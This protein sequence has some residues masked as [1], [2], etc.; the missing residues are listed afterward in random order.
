MNNLLIYIL[1]ILLLIILLKKKDILVEKFEYHLTNEE[2]IKHRLTFKNMPI[3]TVY[4]DSNTQ[5]IELD[6][7]HKFMNNIQVK[8]ENNILNIKNHKNS[9]YY[10]DAFTYKKN[11]KNNK[12]LTICSIP[13]QLLLI[14]NKRMRL[15]SDNTISIGYLNEID[16]DLV[17]II[18]KSQINYTNLNN[19]RFIKVTKDDLIN[20][21]FREKTLDIFVY[22]NTL[23]NEIFNNI[24]KEDFNLVEYDYKVSELEI[25][26]EDEKIIGGNSEYSLDENTLKFYLPF[27]KKEIQTFSKNNNSKDINENNNI[28]YNTLLI[29]TLLFSF[30]DDSTNKNT[31]MNTDITKYEIVYKYIL[32]YFNEFLKINYYLQHF[33]FLELSKK[34]SIEK[35]KTGS[36]INV[37]TE[38]FNENK[39]LKFKIDKNYLIAY[40]HKDGI[41]KYKYNKLKVKDIPI[42]NGDI[43]YTDNSIGVLKDIKEYKV[44]NTDNKYVY[45]N[46]IVTPETDIKNLDEKFESLYRCYQDGT[47]LTKAECIDNFDKTDKEKEIYNWD[48]PCKIDIECPFYLKNKNYV[49]ERGGCNNGYCELPIGLKR[50]SYREY[51]REI[52]EDNFPKCHGCGIND[53]IDCCEKQGNNSKFNGPDYA[54]EGDNEERRLSKF[55]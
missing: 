47:I 3:I 39:S 18:L 53:G 1:L 7:L 30:I 36:F 55:F 51:D 12:V 13:K 14:S 43:L 21:L 32:N 16:L 38:N 42:K 9:F 2:I 45:L 24:K 33:E 54:F 46:G 10:T 41:V 19:F 31:Y 34:W 5:S 52:R 27:S 4:K 20:K 50:K 26:K 23:E 49:N 15:I 44:F 22:F 11:Y 40:D 8:N 6:K 25:T 48:R 29:D 37:M 17:K 35:Q 28:I